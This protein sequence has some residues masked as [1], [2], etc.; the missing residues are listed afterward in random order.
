MNN[1]VASNSLQNGFTFDLNFIGIMKYPV[2]PLITLLLSHSEINN[3][4]SKL[5]LKEE[6]LAID[7]GHKMNFISFGV[8]M[9]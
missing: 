9:S 1:I 2:A 6:K 8:G 3:L 7:Q 5:N 4:H